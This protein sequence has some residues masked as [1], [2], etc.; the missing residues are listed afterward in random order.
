ML[1]LWRLGQPRYS[2]LTY[3]RALATVPGLL[4]QLLQQTSALDLSNHMLKSVTPMHMWRGWVACI[5]DQSLER[6]VG[7]RGVTRD[8]SA[9]WHSPWT[10][11]K[12]ESEIS[13]L[14]D[15]GIGSNLKWCCN[16]PLVTLTGAGV[17]YHA[18][19]EWEMRWWWGW[20]DSNRFLWLRKRNVSQF[21]S[22]F[23]LTRTPNLPKPCSKPK[24]CVAVRN[25]VAN[26]D[27]WRASWS[28]KPVP[29][30]LN[31]LLNLG[32]KNGCNRSYVFVESDRSCQSR[33]TP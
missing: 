32:S 25:I 7:E 5:I 33:E 18:S 29:N 22:T 17:P 26:I 2:L 24:K 13:Q 27:S 19:G 8:L 11:I 30:I 15:G 3:D 4:W 31:S 9:V 23:L 14:E 6:T 28:Y 10:W 20:F 16:A 21:E 12:S 1:Y